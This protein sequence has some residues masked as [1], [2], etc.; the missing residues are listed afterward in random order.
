MHTSSQQPA[1][2]IETDFEASQKGMAM[3]SEDHV[4]IAVEPNPNWVLRTL[5]RQRRQGSGKSCLGFLA[6]ETTTHSGTLDDYF[7]R[8]QMQHMRDGSLNLGRMLRRG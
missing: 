3:P 5:R 6:A 1:L 2:L 4:L 8:G 7:V